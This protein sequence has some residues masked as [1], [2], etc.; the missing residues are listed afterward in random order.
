ML[1]RT[2]WVG[3]MALGLGVVVSTPLVAQDAPDAPA[4]VE[5][6]NQ[7]IS[8][9]DTLHAKVLALANVVPADKF[10]WRPGPGVRSFGEVFMHLASEYYIYTP[11]S[12]GA[13]RSAIISRGPDTMKKFEANSSKD[14][15]L[16][17]LADGYRYARASLLAVAS[18]SLAGKRAL[19]G[20]HYNVYETGIGMTAD[21]HEHLGQLIA[22][23]RMNGIVPPWSK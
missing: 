18:D 22:Y 16:K 10:A 7:F 13:A 4:A 3:L 11:A 9:L 5:Y 8:D 21:M 14:S 20:G 19:F 17:Y 12:F 1:H 2:A 15:V 23:A 6:R